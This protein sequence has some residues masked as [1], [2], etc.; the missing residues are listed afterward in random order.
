MS[1]LTLNQTTA[2]FMNGPHMA[3]PNN[4]RARL[5]L[6]GLVNV[7]DF[8]DFKEDQLNQAFTNMRTAI[9]GITA[10]VASGGVAYVPAVSTIPPV[11]V[12]A[13][14]ALRIKVASIAYHY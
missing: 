5:V 10:V 13:E 7:D 1:A 12:Y 8:D 14:Y 11:L 2:F 3:L 9:T 6:E 4:I